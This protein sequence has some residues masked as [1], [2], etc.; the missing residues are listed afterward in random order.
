M[1]RM[2]GS[3]YRQ[4]I[5]TKLSLEQFEQFAVPHL[6]RGRRGPAPALALHTTFNYILQ[7]LYTGCQWQ[8]LAIKMTARGVPEIHYTRLYRA[9]RRWQADGCIERI[10]AGSV[11]KLYQDGRLDL[12]V[13]LGDGTTIA[14]K[15]G[16]DN[17]LRAIAMN[18]HCCVMRCPN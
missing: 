10:F 1:W 11:R 15:K 17:S 2:T 13:I 3:Q 9:L 6:S 5:P 18:R 16:G 7:L 4:A 12:T 8:A 14:A